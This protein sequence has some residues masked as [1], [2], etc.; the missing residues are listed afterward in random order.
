MERLVAR[1][2]KPHGLRGEV[3]LRLHTDDPE[4]RGS[5]PGRVLRTEAEPGSGVPPDLTV[6]TARVHQG[7]WL[8]PSTGSPTGPAPR[9]CAAR[10]SSSR[11]PRLGRGPRGRGG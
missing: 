10:G 7:S 5:R 3:T 1:I 2:G 9:A 8:C 6:A 4:R 11:N